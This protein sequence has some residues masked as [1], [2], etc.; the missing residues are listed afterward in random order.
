MAGI[1]LFLGVLDEARATTARK[2][3]GVAEEPT[4]RRALQP[5]IATPATLINAGLVILDVSS[6]VASAQGD[7][8]PIA[9]AHYEAGRQR[10]ARPSLDGM[11]VRVCSCSAKFEARAA[12]SRVVDTQHK[13]RS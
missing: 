6:A 12:T 2:R 4:F 1:L 9:A 3:H 8:G 5:W 7:L 11:K 13:Q 10:R